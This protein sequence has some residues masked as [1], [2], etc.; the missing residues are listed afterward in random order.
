MASYCAVHEPPA[1]PSPSAPRGAVAAGPPADRDRLDGRMSL[2]Q[3]LWN[4]WDAVV[5]PAPDF[6]K[7]KPLAAA[8]AAG[9]GRS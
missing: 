6:G 9:A 3:R 8:A 4:C 7:G 2:A 5:D 1:S